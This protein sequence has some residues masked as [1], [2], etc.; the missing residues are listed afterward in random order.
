MGEPVDSFSPAI[1]R[2]SPTPDLR[3][4]FDE[5]DEI[6]QQ[7]YVKFCDLG[8]DLNEFSRRAMWLS[9]PG[10]GQSL[11]KK[12]GRIGIER[13]IS[14]TERLREAAGPL[15]ACSHYTPSRCLSAPSPPVS[16]M[17]HVD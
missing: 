11:K 12:D 15:C 16:L 14:K 8:I 9:Q 3:V 7:H 4:P 5:W 2:P 6:D 17:T 1:H 13:L 10:V